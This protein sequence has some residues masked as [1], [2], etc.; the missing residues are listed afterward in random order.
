MF[1]YQY[2]AKYIFIGDT[3]QLGPMVFGPRSDN[4]F[5][6]QLKYSLLSRLQA[7]GFPV[8]Q[9][10]KTS[11]FRNKQTLQLCQIANHSMEL[12][13]VSQKAHPMTT[14]SGKFNML[15][16][17]KHANV[18]FLNVADSAIGKDSSGSAFNNANVVTV[19]RDLLYRIRK[20]TNHGITIMTPYNAQAYQYTSLIA[21]SIAEC[22]KLG[23]DALIARLQSVHVTTVD[24]YMG[25]ERSHVYLDMVGPGFLSDLRRTV[26]ALTRARD[27]CTIVGDAMSIGLDKTTKG[28]HPLNILIHT[29]AKEGRFES[30]PRSQWSG[31]YHFPSVLSGYGLST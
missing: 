21:F 12:E 3:K 5:Q 14:E 24:S 16:Y 23:S 8:P 11:R 1:A 20:T 6:A 7:T 18:L 10:T 19:I 17:R 9:L 30:I 25:E 22:R 26:V 28:Q 2:D 15:L 13:A 29:L 27:S 31:F 4:P